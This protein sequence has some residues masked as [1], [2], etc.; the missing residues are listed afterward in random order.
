MTGCSSAS[1]TRGSCIKKCE[2]NKET[3]TLFQVICQEED[4]SRLENLSARELRKK[5][6]C[7]F[8]TL[9]RVLDMMHASIMLSGGMSERGRESARVLVTKSIFNRGPLLWI[10]DKMTLAPAYSKQVHAHSMIKS[11]DRPPIDDTSL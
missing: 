9:D 2:S 6:D 1:T 3:V 5:A 4:N 8:K 11:F 10:N 7:L